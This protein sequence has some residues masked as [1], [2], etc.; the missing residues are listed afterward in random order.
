MKLR[1]ISMLAPPPPGFQ[2]VQPK[3]RDLLAG[4][5]AVY[6][7]SL[8]ELLPIVDD[9]KRRVAGVIVVPGDGF[10]QEQLGALLW[11]MTLPVRLQSVLRVLVEPLLL[12]IAAAMVQSEQTQTLACTLDRLRDDL[13]TTRSDYV[14]VTGK[15]QRQLRHMA[16]TQTEQQRGEAELRAILDLLPQPIYATD[17]DGLLLLANAAFVRA[18]RVESAAALL[19]RPEASLHLP[20]QW[21]A[22]SAQIDKAV[23]AAGTS[24]KLPEMPLLGLDGEMRHYDA[25]KLPCSLSA[26]LAVLT[27]MHDISDQYAVERHMQSLNEELERRVAERTCE[28]EEANRELESFSYSVSHDLRAPLRAIM[29][30]SQILAE[31][32][33]GRLKEDEV[34]ILERVQAGTLRMNQLIDDLLMLAQTSRLELQ[35]EPLDLA[36]LAQ[37]VW[38]DFAG[39]RTGLTLEFRC[40]PSLPVVADVRLLRLVLEQ[41]L[42]NAIKFSA[43]TQAA[44]VEVGGVLEEGEQRFFVRDNGAGFDM[45]HAGMLFTPFHRLHGQAEFDGTGIGLA[46]ARRAISRHG[47]NI[48]AEAEP[49][50]G[51][52]FWFTVAADR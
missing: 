5:V 49:G 15:L 39:L 26:E 27:V 25:V 45:V 41:L 35:R 11:R 20:A 40:Q 34:G 12:A 8:D 28:L 50:R 24:M 23:R 36:V 18:Q 6:C 30:F 19:G 1:L 52:C 31:E 13:D 7:R 51:A 9:F 16:D 47:G 32:A 17:P 42:G 22:Q 33:T 3:K 21:L 43:K 46:T 14:R 29:G 4:P 37:S 2:C 48:W 44:V 10:R 38:H